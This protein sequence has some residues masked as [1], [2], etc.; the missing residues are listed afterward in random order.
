MRIGN[1]EY[2]WQGDWDDVAII[3]YWCASRREWGECPGPC[4]TGAEHSVSRSTV[5]RVKR[6]VIVE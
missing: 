4:P 6:M 2:E 1:T 5:R 3:E